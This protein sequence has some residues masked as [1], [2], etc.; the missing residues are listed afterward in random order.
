MNENDYDELITQ[1]ATEFNET[2]DI[3][4]QKEL[5]PLFI[6]YLKSALKHLQETDSQFIDKS[7]EALQNSIKY[8]AKKLISSNIDSKKRQLIVDDCFEK[9]RHYSG[10]AY[11]AAENKLLRKNEKIEKLDISPEE[12]Q[13]LLEG[14]QDFNKEEARRMIS[15]TILDLKYV[16]EKNPQFMSFRLSHI[17]KG[18]G[19]LNNDDGR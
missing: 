17:Y 15:E 11:T 6:K 9:I 13:E 7:P 10:L 19:L 12:L 3:G 2:V 5:E 8:I 18:M 4:E 1:L 14:V 16:E